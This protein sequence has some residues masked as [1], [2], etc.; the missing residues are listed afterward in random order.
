MINKQYDN[1]IKPEPGFILS[2]DI[3]SID[4][5][6]SIVTDRPL[7]ANRTK[8]CGVTPPRISARRQLYDSTGMTNMSTLMMKLAIPVPLPIPLSPASGRKGKRERQFSR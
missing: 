8:K 5:A 3:L 2:I 4:D 7:K 6:N 1:L